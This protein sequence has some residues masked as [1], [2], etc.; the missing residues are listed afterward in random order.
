MKEPKN[1]RVRIAIKGAVREIAVPSEKWEN[2]VR[3]ANAFKFNNPHDWVTTFL[4]RYVS[5]S[6]D[7]RRNLK[8]PLLTEIDKIADT[9]DSFADKGP[10]RVITMTRRETVLRYLRSGLTRAEA[11]KLTNLSLSYISGLMKDE[12]CELP[13]ETVEIPLPATVPVNP[14]LPEETD[15]AGIKDDLA[16]LARAKQMYEAMNEKMA[17]AALPP[18]KRIMWIDAAV[19]ELSTKYLDFLAVMVAMKND[20]NKALASRKTWANRRKFIMLNEGE[21][22]VSYPKVATLWQ[23]TSED[24]LATDWFLL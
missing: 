13:D 8:M 18:V 17:W 15:V 11:A 10:L 3:I 12:G 4:E 20:P 5:D 6:E 2:A 19:T 1:I 23:P 9:M 22:Q 21:L 7:R 16:I 14:A 24:L